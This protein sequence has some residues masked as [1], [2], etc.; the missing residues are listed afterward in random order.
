VRKPKSS[1]TPNSDLVF[2]S[3]VEPTPIGIPWTREDPSLVWAGIFVHSTARDVQEMTP[4]IAF[5]LLPVG[6]K[7]IVSAE[8][9]EMSEH[10]EAVSWAKVNQLPY[11][12]YAINDSIEVPGFFKSSKTELNV[13]FLTTVHKTR[14]TLRDLHGI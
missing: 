12:E 10:L 8:A 11:Y 4:S 9:R 2:Y 7:V 5:R 13:S 6:G 3:K 1:R 14:S